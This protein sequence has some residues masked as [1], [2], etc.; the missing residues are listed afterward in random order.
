MKIRERFVITAVFTVII[1]LIAAQTG[2]YASPPTFTI[3]SP[4]DAQAQ[5]GKT[6]GEWSA[7][8]WQYALGIPA[9]SNPGLD[10]TGANCN[11][12]Q[13]GPVFFLTSTFGGSGVRNECI[14]PA[15]KILFFPLLNTA[16][17]RLRRE[18]EISLRNYLHGF[19]RSTRGLQA[20]ID[21][22]DAGTIVSLE[23]RATPLRAV[24]PNGFFTVVAPEN[25]IFGGVPGQS[26]EWVADGFY[27]MV[28]PLPPGPHTIKFGGVSRNFAADVTYNLVVES[29]ETTSVF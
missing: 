7:T 3:I 12:G 22:T 21:G 18:P 14:V 1:L 6:Y 2:V 11:F 23:S 16:S 20:S 4:Q 29:V 17:Y 13:A 27:L 26:Y 15:G 8:W 9:E 25:N 24:S 28:A 19:I 10:E 5:T